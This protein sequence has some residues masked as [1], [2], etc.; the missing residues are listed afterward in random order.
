MRDQSKYEKSEDN[1]ETNFIEVDNIDN[2]I[3]ENK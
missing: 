3:S 2:S 1:K